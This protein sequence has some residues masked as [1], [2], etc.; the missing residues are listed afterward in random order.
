MELIFTEHL[1]SHQVFSRARVDQ[2]LVFCVVFCWI[3]VC[4]YPVFGHYI[5][6][7]SSN[8]GFWLPILVFSNF[9]YLL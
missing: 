9:C 5:V 4:D 1:S 6:C 8:Y 3:I 7:A 2:S